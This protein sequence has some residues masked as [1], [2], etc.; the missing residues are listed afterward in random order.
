MITFRT[1]PLVEYFDKMLCVDVS[2]DRD[3]E[4]FPIRD[5]R[6]GGLLPVDA[7]GRCINRGGADFPPACKVVFY[8]E[9]PFHPDFRSAVPAGVSF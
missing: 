6:N 1:E 2:V 3:L 5:E 4:H 9:P 8:F 7:L